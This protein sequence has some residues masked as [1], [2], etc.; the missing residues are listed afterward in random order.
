MTSQ[1]I[2]H[3]P[4]RIV[5][6]AI[7]PESGSIKSR[8]PR[9]L[10]LIAVVSGTF[11]WAHAALADS[12]AYLNPS[13]SVGR[14]YDD[15]LFLSPVTDESDS[16]WR[17]SPALEAGYKSS[18]GGLAG[19]YSLDAERYNHHPELN[20]DVARRHAAIVVH[21]QPAARLALSGQGYY[22]DTNTPEQLAPNV[23]L[24]LGR[25]HAKS[26]SFD[27]ELSYEFSQT[28]TG[29]AGY[30][31][32]KDELDGGP[33]T[34]IKISTLGLMHEINRIDTLKIDV[35]S[36]L[37]E[38]GN[39]DSISSTALIGGWDHKLTPRMSGSVAAGPRYTSGSITPE[40]TA[41]VKY[42]LEAGDISGNYTRSQITIIGQTQPVNYQ[43][44]F[45]RFQYSPAPAVILQIAPG[46]VRDWYA[47]TQAKIYRFNMNMAY[48][49][50]RSVSIVGY[51]QYSR[52]VGNI[53]QR[54]ALT[55]D[56]NVIYAGLV[57]SIYDRT[58]D[59]YKE[60]ESSPF[61]TRWPVQTK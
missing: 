27:P 49:M 51:Y 44:V 54:T 8:Y 61:E 35:E 2:Q 11:L 9:Y 56:E 36:D 58:D 10:V 37:Y 31:I 4:I 47:G 3:V 39:A 22:T 53:G 12:T 55:I 6:G 59:N 17:V 29:K 60:R 7:D 18:R 46:Y 15:N 13:L 28:I 57:F 50:N 32:S 1:L 30:S 21:Y 25:I 42:A 43:S 23:G 45:L 38:F 16:I 24:A 41:S 5:S 26:F 33:D 20:S 14:M 19:Y 40:I 48:R 52:Q 34:Y